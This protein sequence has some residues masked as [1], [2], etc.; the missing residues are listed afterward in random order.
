MLNARVPD[1]LLRAILTRTMMVI[2]SN[3]LFS[4]FISGII[5]T[6]TLFDRFFVTHTGGWLH[7]DMAGPGSKADRGTGYGV[8]LVLSLVGAPGFDV[9]S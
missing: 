2:I 4:H 7:V 3:L 5:M 9:R 1:T 8:G 6:I